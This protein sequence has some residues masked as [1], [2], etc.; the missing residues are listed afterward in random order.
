MSRQLAGENV[1]TKTLIIVFVA[2]VGSILV[3][4]SATAQQ[5]LHGHVPEAIAHLH[6]PPT[7]RLAVTN[8][9][10]LAIGLAPRDLQ[11]LDKFIQELYSPASTNYHHYLTP[12]QFTER[13]GPA[14]KDYQALIDFVKASGLNV[15]RQYSNRVVL[16]VKG[17]VAD[18]E[19]TFHVTMRTY[20]HP[21]EARTFYAPDVE[22]SLASGV[23]VLHIEGLDNFAL[24]HPNHKRHSLNQSA[25]GSNA[26][27]APGG[28]LWGNDFR[29][30]Y[31]PGTT[32][33]GAGQSLGLLEFEG[34][35][36]NDITNYEN[37]IGMSTTNRPQLVVVLVDGGATPQSYT[38]NG[39]MFRRH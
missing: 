19:K 36:V 6:L 28:Y 12:A 38:D 8:E 16:D 27:S 15:T 13:F 25:G 4:T 29:D 30:A 10:R 26:G 2:I 34:F 33:T 20:H 24:P 32:L 17:S 21:N 1:K 11:G 31:V 3:P 37:D 14:E 18:I 39:G 23:S 9:L 22:P 5:I 35:Y 7:G